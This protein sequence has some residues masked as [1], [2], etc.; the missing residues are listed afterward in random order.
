MALDATSPAPSRIRLA[1][2]LATAGWVYMSLL[3]VA[4]MLKG[5]LNQPRTPWPLYVGTVVAAALLLLGGRLAGNVKGVLTI[6]LMWLALGM[7]AHPFVKALS[8]AF[9]NDQWLIALLLLVGAGYVA[10]HKVKFS[11]EEK[12]V[13]ESAI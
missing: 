9:L 8:W 5:F 1:N 12:G 2:A 10:C 7:L 13:C 6:V 11:I 3:L 4:L